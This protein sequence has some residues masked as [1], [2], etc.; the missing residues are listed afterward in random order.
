MLRKLVIIGSIAALFILTAA[1]AFGIA[2]ETGPDKSAQTVLDNETDPPDVESHN[3]HGPIC[4]AL[5]DAGEKPC[6][7]N[8]SKAGAITPGG[9]SDNPMGG[10]NLGAWTSVFQSNENSAICGVT[11]AGCVAP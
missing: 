2:V 9:L 7:N 6:P 11:A 8:K 1:P 10:V 3:A 4:G 5:N